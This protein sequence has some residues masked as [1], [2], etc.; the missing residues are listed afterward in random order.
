MILEEESGRLFLIEINARQ[1]QSATF[2][3]QLQQRQAPSAITIFE[4]HLAALLGLELSQMS[5]IEIQSGAQII[6]RRSGEWYR[7]EQTFMK[8]HKKFNDA[9]QKVVPTV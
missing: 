6:D 7:T 2:E 8:E 9:W 3:S 5:L 1:P 4:A